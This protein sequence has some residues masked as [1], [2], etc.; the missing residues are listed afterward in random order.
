MDSNEEGDSD[1][2]KHDSSSKSS[3]EKEL[4]KMGEKGSTEG[5]GFRLKDIMFNDS[6][7]SEYKVDHENRKVEE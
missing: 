5:N 2:K 3:S 4:S 1:S 7:Y 6:Y